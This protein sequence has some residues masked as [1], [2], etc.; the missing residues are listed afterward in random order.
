MYAPDY[1]DHSKAIYQLQK[2]EVPW[3]EPIFW[4][5]KR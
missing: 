4:L 5:L 3:E 2:W 1:L